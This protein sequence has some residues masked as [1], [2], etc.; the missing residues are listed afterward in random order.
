M[1]EDVPAYGLD[2]ARPEIYARFDAGWSPP[3]PVEIR[4]ELQKAHLTAKAAA[5][6]I[7]VPD[8]ASYLNGDRQLSYSAWRLLCLYSGSVEGVG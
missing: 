1:S 2:A 4:A 5:A 8:L 3:V 6:L 7:G